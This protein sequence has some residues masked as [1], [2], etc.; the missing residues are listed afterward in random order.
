MALLLYLP[1]LEAIHQSSIYQQY[2]FFYTLQWYSQ[3]YTVMRKKHLQLSKKI[4]MNLKHVEQKLE[5]KAYRMYDSIYI[6]LKIRQNSYIRI[7][8]KSELKPYDWNGY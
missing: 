2:K 5:T 6:K 1:N 4:Q 7:W 8:C 3:H